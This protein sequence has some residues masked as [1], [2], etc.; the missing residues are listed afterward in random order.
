MYNVMCNNLYYFILTVEIL[1]FN[2]IIYFIKLMFE[3]GIG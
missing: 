3:R 1:H 2:L